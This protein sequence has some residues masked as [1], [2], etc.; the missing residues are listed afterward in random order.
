M[1]KAYGRH[2]SSG[3][4][5][6]RK[7]KIAPRSGM[8]HIS[9]KNRRKKVARWKEMSKY[10][11]LLKRE[12]VAPAP[13][14]RDEEEDTRDEEEA[15]P[16]AAS[17]VA[18]VTEADTA[19]HEDSESKQQPPSGAESGRTSKSV[20]GSKLLGGAALRAPKAIPAE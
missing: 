4:G 13:V 3:P 8:E 15:E 12:P 7:K 18:V 10:K 17:S 20:A 1:Q 16:I 19:V 6:A 11:S 5:A 14:I 2:V 9:L